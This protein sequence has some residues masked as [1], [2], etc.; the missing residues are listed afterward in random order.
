MSALCNLGKLGRDSR[1]KVVVAAASLS[2]VPRGIRIRRQEE[3]QRRE[4]GNGNFSGRDLQNQPLPS[5]PPVRSELRLI[6]GE[7]LN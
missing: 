5:C 7:R 3:G 4:E 1:G 2:R 6:K